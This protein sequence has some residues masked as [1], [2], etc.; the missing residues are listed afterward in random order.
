MLLLD[1][2]GF[3]TIATSLI[4]ATGRVQIST[5]V[6]TSNLCR[7]VAS[8]IETC[9]DDTVD[10]CVD[11]YTYACN[12]WNRSSAPAHAVLE[13]TISK[14]LKEL[15]GNGN[16][17]N[18]TE[19][20]AKDIYNQCLNETHELPF[21]DRTIVRAV[22]DLLGGWSLLKDN[23]NVSDFP[24]DEALVRLQQND[25]RTFSDLS[26]LADDLSSDKSILFFN[27]PVRLSQRWELKTLSSVTLLTNPI[28]ATTQL[29][30]KW[31]PIVKRL[32]KATNAS[33]QWS[34][35]EK[36]FEEAVNLDVMLAMVRATRPFGPT[37]YLKR[38]TFG[39][40][41]RPPFRSRFLANFLPLFN[42]MLGAS[43]VKFQ[44]TNATQFGA[45]QLEYL[46][47]LDQRMAQLE[48]DEDAGLV[49]LGD[50]LWWIALYHY[51]LVYRGTGNCIRLV[52]AAMPLAVSG[53]FSKTY[54]TSEAV[55]KAEELTSEIYNGVCDAVILETTWMDRETQEAAI[56][57]LNHTLRNIGYP[58]EFLHNWTVIED[59]YSKVQAGVSFFDTLRTIDQSNSW[60]NLRKLSRT[61]ARNDP[62]SPTDLT[63]IFAEMVP[64]SN[65]I[66]IPASPLQPPM[67]YTNDYFAIFN[68]AR[69]G[70]D[71]GHEFTH[72]LDTGG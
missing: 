58:E 64:F 14:Q 59:L 30:N 35:V 6:C 51:H 47:K 15:F 13:L 61:N 70:F 48:L 56:D 24:L 62:F 60:I 45:P 54:I 5:P 23:P 32:L 34:S 28:N 53:M 17:T 57:K 68:Y 22:D 71:I 38:L 37:D 44:A 52:K 29:M 72:A 18:P 67:L 12:R 26:V 25:I 31:T 55:Q 3:L 7:Q 9:M 21:D 39:D 40:L 50:W 20:K 63:A 36:R 11:F 69:L 41:S 27:M 66:V 46:Y 16:Y 65:H 1:V 2:V 42:A 10:P 33:A 4:Q 43:A 19:K 8:L 49:I